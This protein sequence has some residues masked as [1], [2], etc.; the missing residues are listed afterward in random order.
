MRKNEEPHKLEVTLEAH[1]CTLTAHVC[2]C[3][4]GKGLCNHVVALLFQTAHYVQLNL[5]AVPLPLACTSELQRWHRPRTQ[6]VHPEPLGQLIVRKPKTLQKTGVKSTLYRAYPGPLPDEHVLASAEKLSQV[7]PRPLL[8]TVLESLSDVE[9]FPSKFGPVPRGSTLSYQCPLVSTVTTGPDT[10]NFPVLPVAGHSLGSN[11]NFV[12]SHH[13][14]LHLESLKVSF[15]MAAEIEENTRLQ[16]K[17]TAWAQI[18]QPRVTA[19]RF[20]EVCHVV[21]DLAGQSLAARIIRGTKQTCAMRR[22]LDLEPEIL[23]TYSQ[24]ANVTVMPCGLVV[25]PEAPHLGASPDGR[26]YDLLETPPFGLV[27]V[28]ST[29]ADNIAGVSFIKMHKDQAKLKQSHK[30]YW[31]VQGQLAVTGLQWCDFVTD[32]K[33]DL[34]IQRIWKDDVFIASMKDKLDAFYHNIYM[35]MYLSMV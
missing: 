19:S 26:V 15:S 33:G 28:K 30:Y 25:H 10:V 18:R 23:R 16:S 3:A 1:N 31:Q 11:F 34:T 24:M 27:E 17:C 13:Q 9:I 21:G 29:T 7:S 14:A 4:A 5:N 20:R 2:S 35:N 8:A 12:P 22:G 6:G 32:T